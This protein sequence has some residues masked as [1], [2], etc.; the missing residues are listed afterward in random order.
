MFLA[1]I[2]GC[3]ALKVLGAR[4]VTVL[5]S[6]GDGGSHFSFH[7]FPTTESIGKTLNDISC[8]YQ[9]PVFPAGSPYVVGVGGTMW[10]EGRSSKPITWA[11]FGGG[12]GGGFSW[13]FPMPPHQNASVAAYLAAVASR[14]SSP[15]ASDTSAEK[16]KTPAG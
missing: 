9:M 14:R 4:G 13:Q 7:Q 1:G 12:S 6:S 16:R 15:S 11:G 10:A 3:T 2:G 5:G 8:R